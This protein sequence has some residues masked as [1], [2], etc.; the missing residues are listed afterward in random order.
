MYNWFETV[1]YNKYHRNGTQIFMLQNQRN[2]S[3]W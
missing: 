1:M 3:M 2:D